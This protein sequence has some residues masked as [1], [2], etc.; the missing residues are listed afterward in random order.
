MTPILERLGVGETV[1]N[2]YRKPGI[3]NAAVAYLLYKIATPARYTVTIGGTQ[4]SVKLLRKA[5][6]MERVPEG[7]SIRELVKDSREQF[8][9]KYDDMKVDIKDKYGE[10]KGDFKDK[11]S[12][13]K[14]KRKIRHEK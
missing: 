10:A 11:V 12:E 7:S 5:G 4:M 3:G 6:Y 14:M 13:L 2:F 8:K 1:L 9:D